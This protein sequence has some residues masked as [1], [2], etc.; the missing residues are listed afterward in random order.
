MKESPLFSKTYDLTRWLLEHTAKFPRH[1][2]SVLGRHIEEAVLGIND[3]LLL[4]VKNASGRATAQ[5]LASYG[6]ERL[7]LYMRL[8][9]DLHICSIPQY[10]YASRQI[11]EVGNLL[12][13]WIKKSNAGNRDIKQEI[14]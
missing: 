12:G 6:L 7:K 11:V 8:S 4:A 1:Q 2:R 10:E 13:G 5:M 14:V 9:L 3:Q